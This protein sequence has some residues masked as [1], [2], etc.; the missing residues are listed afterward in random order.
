MNAHLSPEALKALAEG[1]PGPHRS[2]YEGPVRPLSLLRRVHHRQVIA[3]N[4]GIV[5]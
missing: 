4:G 5:I 1:P 3:P 2:P